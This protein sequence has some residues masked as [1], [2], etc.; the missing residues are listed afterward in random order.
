MRSTCILRL[1]Y[2]DDDDDDGDDDD[3]E[4]DDDDDEDNGGGGD[5]ANAVCTVAT[6]DTISDNAAIVITSTLT[7]RI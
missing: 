1:L 4:A 6:A 7:L 2:S 5:V 3:D